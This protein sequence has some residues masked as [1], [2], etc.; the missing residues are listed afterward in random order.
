[1]SYRDFKH[2]YEIMEKKKGENRDH[3]PI[4]CYI[5]AEKGKYYLHIFTDCQKNEGCYSKCIGIV[6][7]TCM[8]NDNVEIKK[9]G[10]LAKRG[11]SA[12][13]YK[14]FFLR[15][16]HTGYFPFCGHVFPFS[17]FFPPLFSFTNY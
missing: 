16:S 5:E 15:A 2:H 13:V 8:C 7:C 14:S 6:G 17:L 9:G 4:P 11:N 12:P 3:E 1:M 10:L